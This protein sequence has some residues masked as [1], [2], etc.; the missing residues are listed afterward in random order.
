MLAIPEGAGYSPSPIGG[1]AV[2]LPM[3]QSLHETLCLNLISYTA[4]NDDVPIWETDKPQP[5]P[6]QIIF[7]LAHRYTWMSRLIRLEPEE[8]NGALVVR[9]LHYGPACKLKEGAVFNPDPMLAYRVTDVKTGERRALSFRSD[10]ALWRDFTS[11]LPTSG[12]APAVINHALKLL[13]EVGEKRVLPAMV[14]GATNDKAKFEFWRSEL[15]LLP[16]A[17]SSNRQDAVYS[18]LE[19]SLKRAEDMGKSLR[20]A[21]WTLAQ[22]LLSHGDRSPHKDDVSDLVESFPTASVYWSGL[23]QRFPQ[24]LQKLTVNF[25]WREVEEFW[26]NEVLAVSEQAWSA[27]RKAAGDDAFAL[28]A[29]Y[30]AENIYIN[31]VYTLK[32]DLK[33]KESA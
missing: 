1:T 33:E 11:L 24:L 21:T 17:V 22:K 32:N 4:K 28:R 30:S 5:D 19:A 23:E 16:E 26:V 6:E 13:S 12:D 25:V 20:G 31:A 7:G 27:T 29:I 10:R 2:V 14:L 18:T 8:I 9:Y 15:H 3:G